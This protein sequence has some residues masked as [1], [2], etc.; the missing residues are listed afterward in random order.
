MKICSY[1]KLWVLNP[2]P[3]SEI[4]YQQIF[5]NFQKEAVNCRGVL[6]S[7]CQQ[8]FGNLPLLGLNRICSPINSFTKIRTQSL[9]KRVVLVKFFGL[10]FMFNFILP[11]PLSLVIFKHSQ[12]TLWPQVISFSHIFL[13]P[14]VHLL[15]DARDFIAS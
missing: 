15:F 3:W 9:F 6:N 11:S 1:T 14:Q 10:H 13:S 7:P 2:S 4:S 12:V 5:I 8:K